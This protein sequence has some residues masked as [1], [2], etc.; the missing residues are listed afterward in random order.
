MGRVVALGEEVRVTGF[1]LAGARVVPAETPDAVRAAWTSL[2]PDVA[3][4]LLT[5][6]AAEALAG[7]LQDPAAARLTAVLPT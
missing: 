6:S 5:P 4:V 2:E 7:Q 1:A 3:L